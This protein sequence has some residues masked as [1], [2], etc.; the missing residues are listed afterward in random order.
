[1][2]RTS[3]TWNQLALNA[4]AS[5]AT[6]V[7]SAERE[8]MPLEYKTVISS[9]FVMTATAS[10]EDLENWLAPSTMNIQS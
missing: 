7:D 2:T 4:G 10:K 1:M 9:H 8:A 3:P 5:Q 6:A